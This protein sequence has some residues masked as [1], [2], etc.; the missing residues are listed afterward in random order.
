MWFLFNQTT[1]DKYI[2]NL[3]NNMQHT[4]LNF[5]DNTVTQTNKHICHGRQHF[6]C[7]RLLIYCVHLTFHPP[8]E[9]YRKAVI[10]NQSPSDTIIFFHSK[11]KVP[12]KESSTF[13]NE[14]ITYIWLSNFLLA[15]STNKVSQKIMK[16]KSF[17]FKIRPS[18]WSFQNLKQ[19]RIPS[20][21]YHTIK[22]MSTHALFQ[23]RALEVIADA[24]RWLSI[25][26][27]P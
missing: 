3:G 16:N 24:R 7:G 19:N 9:N 13:G 2:R 4:C 23:Q 8:K 15:F 12:P 17:R 11:I 21:N 6:T 22:M 18:L 20:C 26:T 1:N 10:D 14:K 27:S 25:T 5:G